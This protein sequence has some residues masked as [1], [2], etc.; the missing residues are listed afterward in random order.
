MYQFK[1]K[2]KLGINSHI[3]TSL[4]ACGCKLKNQSTLM[5]LPQRAGV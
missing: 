1:K 3:S 5:L 2:V 4:G